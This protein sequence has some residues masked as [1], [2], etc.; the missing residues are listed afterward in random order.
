MLDSELYIN[1]LDEL[2]LICLS[3]LDSMEVMKQVHEEVYGAHQSE[4]KMRWLMRSLS[5]YSSLNL[6]YISQLSHDLTICLY[7]Y[8]SYVIIL[9]DRSVWK[10]ISIY[11]IRVPRPL[12]L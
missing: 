12:L 3:F 1:G 2:L 8:K 6:I 11:R 9:Q 5:L 10:T 7:F 4:V